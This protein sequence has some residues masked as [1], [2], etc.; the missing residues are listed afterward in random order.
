MS[1]TAP[2]VTEAELQQLVT[3]AAT[4]YGWSWLHIRAGRTM[5]GWRVPIEGPLGAGFPDLALVRPRDRRVMLLELKAAKGVVSAIQA[6][7]HELLRCAGLDVR[8]VRPGDVDALF[9]VL[10]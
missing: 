3:D 7:K 4:A 10:R 8:V 5:H 2:P 9:E 6:T 1:A